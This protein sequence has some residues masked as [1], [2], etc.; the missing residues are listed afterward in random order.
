LNY[1][2]KPMRSEWVSKLTLIQQAEMAIVSAHNSKQT[3]LRCEVFL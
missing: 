1:F 2:L 3:E